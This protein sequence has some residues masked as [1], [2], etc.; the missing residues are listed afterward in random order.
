MKIV[1]EPDEKKNEG[2]FSEKKTESDRQ[3]MIIDG[4]ASQV[5]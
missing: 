4:L 3:E 1:E 2:D 5:K